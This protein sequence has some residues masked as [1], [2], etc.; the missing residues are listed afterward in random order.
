VPII[1]VPLETIP[2]VPTT[3]PGAP[4]VTAPEDLSGVDTQPALVPFLPPSPFVLLSS[5]DEEDSDDQDATDAE[6]DE[7]A[8]ESAAT[9]S[10]TAPREPS[11]RRR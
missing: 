4:L 7:E 3:L 8:E 6:D 5:D 2:D 10:E 9:R 11:A 1:D